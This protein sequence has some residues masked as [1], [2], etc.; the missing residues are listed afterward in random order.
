[1]ASPIARRGHRWSAVVWRSR[2]FRACLKSCLCADWSCVFSRRSA[3]D[4][5]LLLCRRCCLAHLHLANPNSSVVDGLILV[6]EAGFLLGVAFLWS[7]RLWLPIGLH[8]GWN[9]SL[10]AIFGGGLSGQ[11]VSAIVSATLVGPDW[12]SGGA[13]GIEG[14]LLSTITC[15]AAGCTILMLTLR[16]RGLAPSDSPVTPAL[17][18][19]TE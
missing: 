12:L 6:I 13:F 15:S 7:E 3:V 8:G 14:S 5:G 4:G 16:H 17:K 1:M 10:A 18:T 19:T 2:W 11:Q 9:F